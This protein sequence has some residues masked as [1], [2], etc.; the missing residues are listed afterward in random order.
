MKK[1]VL[2]PK[3]FLML[4]IAGMINAFGVTCFLYPVNLYDSG[5][6]GTSMLLAQIT[7]DYLTLSIFLL[8]LNFPLFFY[9]YKKM[10]ISFTVYS[11]YAV[12]I[13][14]M[15]TWMITDILPVDVTIASP[16]AEQDLLLCAIFGGLIFGIGSGLTIRY[17]GAI[18]GVEIL[19]ILFSKKLG[20]T[21]GTFVMGYN[22]ILYVLAGMVMDSWILPLY[23]IIT[24]AVALK[25]VDFIAEGLDKAKSVMIITNHPDNICE[26]LSTEFGN[27]ITLLGAKGYYSDKEK[28]MIY[29]VVNRF[30]INKVRQIV[31]RE[32]RHAYVTIT[33]VSDVLTHEDA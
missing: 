22:I 29:F 25:A 27:G 10:G 15:G 1:D 9:G 30:Q 2:Q 21:V 18:D 24:Y 3:N 33:E 6:S 11:I 4:T 12:F 5:I 20:V 32:D 19:A 23:S 8:I 13:Y 31:Q 17:G 16:L 26:A 7:P 14:S 28:T